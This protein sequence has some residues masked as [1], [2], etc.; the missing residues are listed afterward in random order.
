MP[1]LADPLERKTSKPAAS[2]DPTGLDECP[3]LLRNDVD[4]CATFQLVEL[5]L[6]DFKQVDA[7]KEHYRKYNH[8]GQDFGKRSEASLR[9]RI[10]RNVAPTA[11][12]GAEYMRARVEHKVQEVVQMARPVASMVQE[13]V[14]LLKWSNKVVKW[15]DWVSDGPLLVTGPMTLIHAVVGVG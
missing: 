14:N 6:K 5:L 13:A 10:R 1:T 9:N 4:F 3:S 2:P 7:T 8:P 11:I 15:A 12:L